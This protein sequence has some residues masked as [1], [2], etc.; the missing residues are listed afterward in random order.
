MPLVAELRGS[1]TDLAGAD[2]AERL[3]PAPHGFI[4]DDDPACRQNVLDHPRAER[5]ADREPDSLLDDVH[6]GVA[7]NRS[8]RSMDVAL[9]I[10]ALEEPMFADASSP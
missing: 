10:I 9:V 1:P 7:R 2:P 8:P 3:C 4:V 6:H 5:K